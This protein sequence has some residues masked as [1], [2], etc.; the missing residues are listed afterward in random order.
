MRLTSLSGSVASAHEPPEPLEEV[1]MDFRFQQICTIPMPSGLMWLK[2]AMRM[3]AGTSIL[4]EA[5]VHEDFHAETAF[6]AVVAF[7]RRYGCP[8]MLT[9][10]RRIK[11]DGRVSVDGT[12]YYIKQAFAGQ[13]MS[14]RVNA[15]ERC[16]EVLQEN[17]LIKVLPIKGLLGKRLPLDEYIALMEERARSQ[18]RQRLRVLH[19]RLIQAR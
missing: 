18:E 8:K 4:L 7:L 14:L 19:Q 6:R 1:Q 11:S 5:F 3:D 15:A 17:T 13:M 2:L 9:F 12:D 10:A 16:L